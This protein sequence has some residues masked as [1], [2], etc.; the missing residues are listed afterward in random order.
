MEKTY[1]NIFYLCSLWS[2]KPCPGPKPLKV[3]LREREERSISRML[4]RMAVVN[5]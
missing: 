5:E 4:L 1:N 2:D 3:L